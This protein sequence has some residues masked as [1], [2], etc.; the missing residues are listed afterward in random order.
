MQRIY[1]FQ[2]WR[3]GLNCHAWIGIV[4]SSTLWL[5]HSKRLLY[6][7]ARFVSI[8]EAYTRN[9][10]FGLVFVVVISIAQEVEYVVLYANRAVALVMLM[11]YSN[12]VVALICAELMLMKGR[13]G[14][15]SLTDVAPWCASIIYINGH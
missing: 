7:S 10:Y 1:Y 13:Y 9:H 14:V 11:T 4:S 2:R 12:R 8:T 15:R 3:S 5:G 6:A